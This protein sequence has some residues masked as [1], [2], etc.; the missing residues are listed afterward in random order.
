MNTIELHEA[1][2]EK[3]G[4]AEFAV[5]LKAAMTDEYRLDDIHV[6]VREMTAEEERDGE[7]ELLTFNPETQR[8]DLALSASHKFPPAWRLAD[9]IDGFLNPD[10]GGD[11]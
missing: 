2:R 7:T 5:K 8:F 1:V 4:W 6:V 3:P 9:R 11:G 10:A